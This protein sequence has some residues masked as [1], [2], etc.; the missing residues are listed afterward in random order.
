MEIRPL[1]KENIPAAAALFVAGFKQLRQAVQQLPDRMEDPLIVS[2]LLERLLS[3]SKGMAA[4]TDGRLIGYIGW[5]LVEG[6]RGTGRKAGYVPEWAHATIEEH[7]PAIYRHLYRAAADCWSD[8][9]CDMHAITLLA[10]DQTAVDTWFWN[11]F[12]LT[13]VDAIRSIG[14]LSFETGRALVV[15]PGYTVRKAS[16]ADTEALSELEKEHARHYSQSPVLMVPFKPNDASEYRRFL[17]HSTN[18]AWLAFKDG[19]P[20][21]YLRF[22]AKG[23]GAAEIVHG[24]GSIANT[25]A[26]VRPV[27]RGFGLASLMLEAALADFSSKGFQRC[28]VDFESFNPEAVS[29]WL[30]YF[31]P[32][33]LSVFRVPEAI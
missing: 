16:L 9:G 20:A 22:Q 5:W 18:Y 28:S 19:E 32:V 27:H 4:F 21:G 6:F 7:K 26:Y 15:P 23:D 14:P 10:S 25:G 24:S 13:V 30:R 2:S 17:I 11:G 1:Q 33:C 31:R 3:H 8:A 29:F 12:G